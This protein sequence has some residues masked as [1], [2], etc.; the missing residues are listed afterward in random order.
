LANSPHAGQEIREAGFANAEGIS[1]EELQR[2]KC[3]ATDLKGWRNSDPEK[4][5]IAGRLRRETTMTFEW[6]ANRLCMGAP[7]HLAPLLKSPPKVV[8]FD[9]VGTIL[10]LDPLR[11]HLKAAGLPEQTLELWFEQILRNGFALEVSGV[12][13]SFPVVALATLEA[14]L[15]RAA[16]ARPERAAARI[17]ERFGE[18]LPVPDAAKAFNLL[19]QSGMRLVTLS[20]AENVAKQRGHDVFEKSVSALRKL[21]AIGYGRT[22]PLNLVYNPIGSK[23]PGPQAELEADYKEVL[24]REF[25]IVFNRLFTITNQ[26]IARFAEDLR[27]QG[28]SEEYTVLSP[29]HKAWM[30][31]CM[32]SLKPAALPPATRSVTMGQCL[33]PRPM[34]C[35]QKWP[36]ATAQRTFR[37]QFCVCRTA[38]SSVR[39]SALPWPLSS[40][41]I[42]TKHRSLSTPS[43]PTHCQ[44]S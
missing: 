9:V 19:R 24:G 8:A 14:L 10:P 36:I 21:N 29:L 3:S 6:I 43:T 22:L 32:A 31:I 28:K 25:G 44:G 18:L 30:A 7:T 42:Q 13:N 35:L 12:Y 2:V 1:Q 5:R 17:L 39:R 37:P 33:K 11:E 34:V 38:R 15:V 27:R 41:S 4:I 20:N 23:L 40:K 26:P 16:A